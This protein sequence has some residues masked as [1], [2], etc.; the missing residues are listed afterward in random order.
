MSRKLNLDSAAEGDGTGG[1]RGCKVRRNDPEWVSFYSR[2]WQHALRIDL[3]RGSLE[4]RLV[5]P[6][7]P[8]QPFLDF[9]G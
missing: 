1:L 8:H 2:E 3:F 4:F 5:N 9:N 7:P 6:S